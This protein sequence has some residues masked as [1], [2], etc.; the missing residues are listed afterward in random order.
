MRRIWVVG[1]CGA[2]KS[3]V[4]AALGARLGLPVVRMDE[5]RWNPGWVLTPEAEMADRV[6]AAL[7]A[8]AWVF[9]G[10]A[11][12]G[13]E[14]LLRWLP[15]ADLVVWLDLPLRVTFPRLVRRGV[16][17]SLRREPCCNGNR[18]TLRRTFFSPHSLL[19]Y[20]LRNHLP[21]RR[22]LARTLEGRPHVRLG[23]AEAVSRWL[24][25]VAGAPELRA[26]AGRSSTCR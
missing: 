3:T 12:E 18:E 2:G 7:S 23:S 20:A 13:E 17:R 6:A 4:A 21:R 19:L 11:A 10:N 1:P 22:H 5:I 25:G 14:W 26:R 24:A 9:D 8:A 16:R 15:R